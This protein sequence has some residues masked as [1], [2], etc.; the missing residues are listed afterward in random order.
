M[1]YISLFG[2]LGPGSNKQ[3]KGPVTFFKRNSGDTCDAADIHI[4]TI[5]CAVC[6]IQETHRSLNQ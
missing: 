4:I 1:D 3:N 5:L 2:G 6:V